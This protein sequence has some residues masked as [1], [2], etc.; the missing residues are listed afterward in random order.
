[1]GLMKKDHVRAMTRTPSVAAKW[2]KVFG[3]EPGEDDVHAM[4][5]ELEPLM[6]GTIAAY[7][8]P[9][10]GLHRTVSALRRA[11]IKIGSSTGYTRPMMDVLVPEAAKRGYSP[12]SIVCSSDVPHG[13]PYPY[14]CYL[15]AI[16]LDVYPMEAMVKVGDTLADIEEGR[17]AGMW[18]VGLTRTSSDFG[19]TEAQVEALPAAQRT[20]RL[21]EIEARFLS[22]GAHFVIEDIAG[23]PDVIEA[24]AAR[25]ARGEHPWG[26]LHTIGV[27]AM[28]ISF[29]HAGACRQ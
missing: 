17:N 18:T 29:R 14:M 6:V 24:I 21:R 12:D 23:V 16:R 11:G 8:E 2:R 28:S 7:A 10:P 22:A 15:N 20:R 19:L 4:Y 13:R 9:I 25:L 3:Q 26:P 27:R 5:L 1:M